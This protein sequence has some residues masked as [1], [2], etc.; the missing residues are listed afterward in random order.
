CRGFGGSPLRART[1]AQAGFSLRDGVWHTSARVGSEAAARRP[2]LVVAAPARRVAELV[3]GRVD[4]DHPQLGSGDIRL[5]SGTVRMIFL[6]ETPIGRL[7][8]LEVCFRV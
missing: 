3:P 7:D 8:H 5:G 2:L 1:T 4:L 6:G